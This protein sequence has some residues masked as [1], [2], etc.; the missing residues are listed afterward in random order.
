MNLPALPE[1]NVSD[2]SGMF[3]SCVRLAWAPLQG[4]ATT[5][6]IWGW[7]LSKAAILLIFHNLAYV[8]NHQRIDDGSHSG[9]YE[10]STADLA[11]ATG[12]RW[13]VLY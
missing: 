9:T 1:G 11:A 2:F 3:S 6:S 12:K 7:A 13:T 4:I 10:L 5:I 8:S